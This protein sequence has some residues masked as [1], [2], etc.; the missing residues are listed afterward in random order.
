M[1]MNYLYLLLLV[2]VAACGSFKD[3]LSQVGGSQSIAHNAILDFSNTSKLYK[4]D[5]V[6]SVRIYN[7]LYASVLEETVDGNYQWVNGEPYTGLIAVSIVATYHKM[8]LPD[9]TN[10][11]EK[12]G[13]VPTRYFEKDGKLFYWQD[14]DFELTQKALTIFKKYN[15]LVENNLAGI[16]EF[17]DYGTNDAQKGVNYYFCTNDLTN[18]KKVTTNKAIGYYTPPMINCASR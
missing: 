18:Y 6:F 5:S 9:S 2:L 10:I 14:D 3:E 12:K 11:D 7:P 15:L 13:T 8:L 1:K 16:I 17:Y 4:K